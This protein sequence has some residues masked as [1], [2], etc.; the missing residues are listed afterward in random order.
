MNITKQIEQLK[1]AAALL[2]TGHPWEIHAKGEGLYLHNPD[3][4]IHAWLNQ[5]EFEIRPVLVTPEDGRP[6]NNP[7]NLTAEQVGVGYKLTLVEQMDSERHIDGQIW[8][9]DT[10]E[11]MDC[12]FKSGWAW[13]VSN[14]IRVP[15]STP[16][17]ETKTPWALPEPPAGRRWHNAHLFKEGDILK[18]ERP[19]LVGETLTKGD[20]ISNY[21]NNVNG[22]AGKTPDELDFYW[23][24][25]CFTTKRPLP[26]VTC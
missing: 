8:Y 18:G 15:L 2:E 6:I 7:L 26:V 9:R 13:L 25:H 23:Q 4:P 10:V 11:W 22:I 5:D 16:Y 1:L 3:L 24:T 12:P 14:T 20:R 21:A 17:P 19:V